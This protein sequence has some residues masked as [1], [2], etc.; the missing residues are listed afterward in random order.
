MV[1]S[2]VHSA[3]TGVELA[4]IVR[5][6]AP[7]YTSQYAQVMMPSQKKALAD[8]AA[9]C[10]KELGERLYRGNDCHESFW[11][12]ARWGGSRL[13]VEK[14]DKL[15]QTVI[16]TSHG[17]FSRIHPRA[18]YRPQA[19]LRKSRVWHYTHHLEPL[20]PWVSSRPVR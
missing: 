6:F 12:L 17:F 19:Q 15:L 10:T 11:R 13:K 18:P 14:I 3:R 1:D 8:I 4:D 9:C 20:R 5:R 2:S 16:S 7:Q